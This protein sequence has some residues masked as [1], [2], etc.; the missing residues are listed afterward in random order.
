LTFEVE[1][2]EKSSLKFVRTLRKW[3]PSPSNAIQVDALNQ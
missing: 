2:I 3:I 1:Q